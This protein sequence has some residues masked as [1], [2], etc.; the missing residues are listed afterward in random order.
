MEQG[1]GGGGGG[2]MT[3]RSF[4]RGFCILTA[5]AGALPSMLLEGC[6]SQ[7]TI[8]DLI[9]TL[10]SAAAQLATYENNPTLAAKLQTDVAAAANAVLNWKKG[11]PSQLVVEALNLVEDDLNLF[12][13]AGPYVPLIDLAIA[14]VEGILSELGLT[15]AAASADAAQPVHRHRKIIVAYKAPKNAKAFAAK[16]NAL[17]PDA[18][19]VTAK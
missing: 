1:I 8:A 17:A 7:Q 6:E 5:L 14:T 2:G 11:T 3:R 12:P 10:G 16:W 13:L 9:N 15:P 4:A 18:V 19:K